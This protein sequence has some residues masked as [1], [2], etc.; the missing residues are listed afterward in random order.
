MVARLTSSG[1]GVE[2][3]VGKAGAGKTLALAAARMSWESSGYRVLGTASRPAQPE[4]C[5]TGRASNRKPW[6]RCWAVSRRSDPAPLQRRRGPRRGRH[7]RDKSLARLVES[8]DDAGAK[9]SW[10]EIL[11][12]CPRSKLVARLPG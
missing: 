5:T 9:S 2:V 4:D 8:A 10:S 1:S 12:S 6:P 7:G 11:A 3:V